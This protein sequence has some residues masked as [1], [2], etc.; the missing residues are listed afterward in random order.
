MS[1][2]GSG[3]V[4]DRAWTHIAPARDGRPAIG[5][6]TRTRV[7]RIITVAAALGS[8]VL[9]VQALATAVLSAAYDPWY[10]DP[11]LPVAFIPL[12][13]MVMACMFG[14]GVRATAGAFAVVFVLALAVWPLTP[15]A[16]STPTDQDPWIWF[17]VNIATLAAVLAFPFPLQIAWTVLAPILYGL[18]RL[19][20]SGFTPELG[21]RLLLDVSFAIILGG[22]LLT[23]GWLFRSV[24][25]NVDETRAQAVDLYARAA[26]TDAAEQERVTVAALMHDSVLAALIA[27][28]RADSPRAR[29]LAV[30]MAREALAGLASTEQAGGSGSDEPRDAASLAD[31]IEEAAREMGV[32]LRVDRRIEAGTTLLPGRVAE[33]LCLAATQAVANSVQHAGAEGL[34]ATVECARGGI[35]IDVADAGPGFDLD[36]V[37]ADRLGIR[38]SI[39]ARMASVGGVGRVT[40]GREGTRVR[41][42]WREASE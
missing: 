10:T 3:V 21:F 40:T 35:R 27:A 5:S 15:K 20:V 6:F 34:S 12:A 38:G 26:A 14:R 42:V 7:E 13:V 18:V 41:L 19:V 23:L 29:T 4:L 8:L 11:L 22:V 28:E 2:D 24:A 36:A 30:A 25:A 16:A 37:P 31:D 9:G 17:L 39:V 32:R 1:A 33:A